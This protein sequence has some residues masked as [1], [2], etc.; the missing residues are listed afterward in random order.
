MAYAIVIAVLASYLLGN[1]NGAV[2]MSTLLSHEDVREH[3]SGN[4]GLTNFA[5]NYGGWNSLLVVLIDGGKAVIATMLSGLL[6]KPYGLE[7]EGMMLGAVAVSLGHDFPALLGFRGGKGQRY[8]GMTAPPGCQ[9]MLR[10][11]NHEQRNDPDRSAALGTILL[12]A[13]EVDGGRG[14]YRRSLRRDWNAVPLR[15]P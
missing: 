12:D 15:R 13:F 2:C 1:L 7:A 9:N 4:A 10:R 11:E 5:R 8:G 3:G 6:L 14:G